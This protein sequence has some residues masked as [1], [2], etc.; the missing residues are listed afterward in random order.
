[1]KK[2]KILYLISDG[3]LKLSPDARNIDIRYVD[4]YFMF[5]I[6]GPIGQRYFEKLK[7]VYNSNMKNK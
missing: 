4:G 1:M 5:Y 2:D 7:I 3:G 6:Q